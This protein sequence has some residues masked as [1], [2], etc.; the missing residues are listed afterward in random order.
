MAA[1]PGGAGVGTPQTL[2]WPD[3]TDPDE[4][5]R[6]KVAPERLVRP[7]P[8][9]R[10]VCASS[11]LVPVLPPL[12]L[13]QPDWRDGLQRF[14]AGL[15]LADPPFDE[16][17]RAIA[18][19]MIAL[20]RS[21]IGPVKR[22]AGDRPGGAGGGGRRPVRGRVRAVFHPHDLRE[23]FSLMLGL[24]DRMGAYRQV[25]DQHL[26]TLLNVHAETM[27][28]HTQSVFHYAVEAREHFVAGM[29]HEGLY[30]RLGRSDERADYAQGAFAGYY[31]GRWYYLFSLMRGESLP[32]GSRMFQYYWRA[33]TFMARISP[34]GT[35]EQK[36]KK[37]N[38]PSRREFLFFIR[39][40]RHVQR[41]LASNP[42][43][44]KRVSAIMHT[45]PS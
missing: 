32:V 37:S 4:G 25:L 43:F 24:S 15:G 31:N 18:E 41:Q 34:D 5:S 38:L 11:L 19:R 16:A 28:R 21:S 12:R 22:D 1:M 2:P 6:R 45:L 3:A 35:L 26:T 7:E 40:D 30:H 10:D 13:P 39:K 8:P 29:R 36:P 20:V 33:T 17:E 27:A 14:L 23:A 9:E 42:E 44:A